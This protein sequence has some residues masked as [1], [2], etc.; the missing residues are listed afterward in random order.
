MTLPWMMTSNAAPWV[1]QQPVYNRT[2][3]ISRNLTVAGNTDAI[4]A[5]GYSGAEQG[6]TGGTTEGEFILF[7]KLP[8]NIQLKTAGRTTKTGGMPGDAITAPVWTILIPA[9]AISQ[10]DIRDRDIITDDEDYRYAVGAN[11]WTIAGY[12]LSAIREEA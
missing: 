6:S 5:D 11:V 3:F 2:V 7:T 10:Y 8:A 12:E 9:S 1:L 4:G